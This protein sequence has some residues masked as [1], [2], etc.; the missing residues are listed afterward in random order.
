[1]GE[2]IKIVSTSIIDPMFFIEQLE[3]FLNARDIL[4]MIGDDEIKIEKPLSSA[5]Q[6]A[7]LG[8]VGSIRGRIGYIEI[9]P[10]IQQNLLPKREP[11]IR[12]KGGIIPQ[13]IAPTIPTFPNA[14]SN[15]EIFSEVPLVNYR[16]MFLTTIYLLKKLPI[17]FIEIVKAFVLRYRDFK[18]PGMLI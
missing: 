18:K 16:E 1:M 17:E 9:R 3:L 2:F 8:I 6:Q 15:E 5:Q 12:D 7:N 13:G 10:Q 4:N 11:A 14:T